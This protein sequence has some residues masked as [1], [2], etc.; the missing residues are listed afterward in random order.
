MNDKCPLCGAPCEPLLVTVDCTNTRCQN[1]SQDALER[2]QKRTKAVKKAVAKDELD[3]M[4][5][6]YGYSY[7]Y[8]K[9]YAPILDDSDT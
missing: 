8:W 4:E 2:L 7:G 5:D 6:V 3:E 1:F 9:S